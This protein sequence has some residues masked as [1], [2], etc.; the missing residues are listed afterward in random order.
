MTQLTNEEKLILRNLSI[1]DVR[2]I[3]DEKYLMYIQSLVNKKL[4]K[5]VYNAN[6]LYQG[7]VGYLLTID[8]K[9][10]IDKINSD[11]IFFIVSVILIP[12]ILFFLN[13]FF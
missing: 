2:M 7:A 4:I 1:D 12:L 6:N 10:V 9:A 5:P 13:K 8:G 3:Y 11:K